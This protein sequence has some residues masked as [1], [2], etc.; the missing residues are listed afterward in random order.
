M[1][2]RLTRFIQNH[3]ISFAL[4]LLFFGLQQ[5]H[6]LGFW[7]VSTVWT[8]LFMEVHLGSGQGSQCISWSETI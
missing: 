1:E 4:H 2:H 8:K 3:F 6:T 7:W 5:F